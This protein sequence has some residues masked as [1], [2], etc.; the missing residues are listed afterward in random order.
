MMGRMTRK[1]LVNALERVAPRLVWRRR[2]SAWNLDT[3]EAEERLLHWTCNRRKISIDVGA[4]AGTY[5]ARL[6][7]FSSRVVAFEPHPK[8]AQDLRRLFRWSRILAVEQV[9]LSNDVG[10]AVLR[11]PPDRPMLSTIEGNNCLLETAVDCVSVKRARLDDYCLS[12]VGFIK[13]DAEGHEAAILAGAERTIERDHPTLL[14][15]IEDRHNPGSLARVSAFLGT[16]TYTGYFLL[17]DRLV[18]IRFFDPDAH[19]NRKNLACGGRTGTYINNFIF[20]PRDRLNSIPLKV[21]SGTGD[22]YV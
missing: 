13:I 15:E 11:A 1:L 22:N 4:A 9:A 16:L 14:I 10:V 19:Q 12:P 20:L 7:L 3:G 5:S 2:I 21:E 8:A 18:D 6:L 17:G